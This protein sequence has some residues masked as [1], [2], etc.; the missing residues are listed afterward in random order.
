MAK[1]LDGLVES[2]RTRPLD[3]GP[4]RFVWADALS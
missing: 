3:Q 2:F 4:Y 1:E